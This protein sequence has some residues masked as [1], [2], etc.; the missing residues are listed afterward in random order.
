MGNSRLTNA[1]YEGQP[2]VRLDLGSS[3]TMQSAEDLHIALMEVAERA[4]PLVIE[5]S[6]IERLSTV[7]VQ[8]LLAAQRTLA[9][10]GSS[11]VV[12]RPSEAFL[13]AFR[14]L[15]IAPDDEGMILSEGADG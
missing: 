2:A 12:R 14:D 11:L 15:G 6:S 8:L 1:H 3:Q 10:R 9:D 5:A 4:L 7:S 13:A